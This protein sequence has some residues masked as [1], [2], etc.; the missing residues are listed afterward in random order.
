MLGSIFRINS[1]SSDNDQVWTVRMTLCSDEQ[2]DLKQ[3]LVHM[4]N[5]NGSGQTNLRT[6]GNVLSEMGKFDEA[7]Y[8][9]TRMLNQLSPH[10]LLLSD[11]YEDLGKIAS[12][13]GEYDISIRWHQKSLAIKKQS[14]LTDRTTSDE[15]SN[16]TGKF[17]DSL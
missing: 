5:Q 3:V 1:V 12:H 15:I 7:E 9:Y 16:S 4:Q 17:I 10:N 14:M 11:L 13:K 6:L 2:H 8:Y